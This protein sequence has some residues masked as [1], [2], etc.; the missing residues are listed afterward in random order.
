MAVLATLKKDRLGEWTTLADYLADLRRRET[1]SVAALAGALSAAPDEQRELGQGDGLRILVEVASDLRLPKG[2]RLAAARCA[3]EAGASGQLLGALFLGAGDLATDPRMG[4]AAKKLVDAGLASA[5]AAGAG[6][7]VS[8]EAGAFAR[9]AQAGASAV[10]QAR[11][12][13]LLGTA[14]QGHAGAA[15]ALFALGAAELPEPQRQAWAKLLAQTCAANRSAPAAAKRLGLAPPWP[16][17]LPEAFAALVQEAEKAS[18]GVVATDAAAAPLKAPARGPAPPPARPPTA[19]TQ[20]AARLPAPKG[21]DQAVSLPE[22]HR[23]G[24]GRA[25]QAAAE[26]D[27]AS[28]LPRPGR[29][30]PAE[31]L[32]AAFPARTERGE[33]AAARHHAARPARHGG[34]PVRRTRSPDPPPG[35]VE[36][37]QLRVGDPRVAQPGSAA[38]PQGPA[39]RR[40]VRAPARGPVRRSARGGRTSLRGGRGARSRTRPARSTGRALPRAVQEA[41]EGPPRAARPAA[42]ARFRIQRDPAGALGGRRPSC[43]PYASKS[44]GHSFLWS[45]RVLA[46]LHPMVT[47]LGK[48]IASRVLTVLNGRISSPERQAD[49]ELHA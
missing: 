22:G 47:R 8:M 24:G 14:P 37:V 10:G 46:S 48:M 16:P 13:E 44:S 36:R 6:Q 9:A 25:G 40:A 2:S 1:N 32:G 12:R 28:D 33:R 19:T 39:C 23:H 41:V 21:P 45:V 27:A 42:A 17:G 20:R 26:A 31:A 29:S 43:A 7:G 5:L 4:A 15:A 30:G 11:I 49:L 38:C 35:P 18:A 34:A 3:L